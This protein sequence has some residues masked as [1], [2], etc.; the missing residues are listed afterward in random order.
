MVESWSME[1]LTTRE[2]DMVVGEIGVPMVGYQVS[3]FL[4]WQMFF[5]SSSYSWNKIY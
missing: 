5:K 1:I 3:Y 4:R 2:N